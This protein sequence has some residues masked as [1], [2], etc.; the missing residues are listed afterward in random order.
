MSGV[1]IGVAGSAGRMGT[2]VARLLAEAGRQPTLSFEKDDA[3][4]LSQADVI[5][6]F[7]TG[8]ASAKLAN[9]CAR[10]GKVAL[11]I[12]S[13]GFDATSE[14]LIADAARAIPIVKSGNYSL[15][16]NVMLG[17]VAQAAERLAAADYDI[18]IFE[19]HHKRKIDAPSGTALMLGEAVAAARGTTLA[20]AAVR[21]RDGITG[22]REQGSIGFSVMRGGGIVGE[23]SLV[24]AAEDEVI[25]LS[26]SARERSLFARGAI[27][28]AQWVANKPPGLYS[29]QD[30]LGFK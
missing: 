7:T 17:L 16:V 28:A 10:A 3:P 15:G 25:T 24:F 27:A 30:V 19:A 29:M 4:D 26:H 18:E 11:V 14:A 2:T 8:E 22:P 9:A 21:V 1:R 6:D 20:D 13:T 5:I 12:G 23:H